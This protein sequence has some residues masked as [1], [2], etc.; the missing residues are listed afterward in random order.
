MTKSVAE[1]EAWLVQ[2][3]SEILEVSPTSID[4]NKTFDEYGLDSQRAIELTGDLEQWLGTRLDATL[5]W[6]Y[7]TIASLSEQLANS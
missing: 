3:V 4:K 2:R 6:D 1:I 5:A 7:P